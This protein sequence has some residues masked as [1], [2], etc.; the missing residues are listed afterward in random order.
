MCSFA[1]E[2]PAAFTWTRFPFGP[3]CAVQYQKPHGV[4][5]S[6][7]TVGM[8]GLPCSRAYSPFLIVDSKKHLKAA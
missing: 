8:N 5:D 2:C 3:L 1:F 4:S 7:V 6:L